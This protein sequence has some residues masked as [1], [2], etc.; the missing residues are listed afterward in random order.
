MKKVTVAVPKSVAVQRASYAPSAT[1][2]ARGT[3]SR[4]NNVSFGD[5]YLQND[6]DWAVFKAQVQKAIVEL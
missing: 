2:N 5:V 6:M 1:Q 4:I 3:I